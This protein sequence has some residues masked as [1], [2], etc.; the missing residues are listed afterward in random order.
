VARTSVTALDEVVVET[1][2]VDLGLA[3]VVVE[4]V[5]AKTVEL[6]YFSTTGIYR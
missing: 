6:G 1:F 2:V 4:R 3:V 5:F